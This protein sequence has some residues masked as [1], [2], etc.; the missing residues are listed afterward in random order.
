MWSLRRRLNLMVPARCWAVRRRTLLAF[1]A[2]VA[3]AA[4]ALSSG[5]SRLTREEEMEA[6]LAQMQAHLEFLTTL[7]RSRQIEVMNMQTKMVNLGNPEQ[8]EKLL[9]PSTTVSPEVAQ[10]LKNLTGTKTASGVDRKN[11]QPQTLPFIY[12]LMPH[13]LDDVYSL[14]PAFHMRG[15]R[16][17]AQIVI[18]IPTVKRDKESYLMVTLTHLISGM[19]EADQKESVIIVMVGEPDLEF[20]INTAKQIETLFPKEVESGLIEVISPPPSY[21]PNFDSFEPTLGDSSKRMRW[22]TKQN[23][24]T[25]FLMAYAQSRGTFYLMLEDDVIAKQHYMRDIKY[26]TAQITIQTPQWFFIE[27]CAFGGIGKLFRSADL[28]H[29]ITYVQL[30]YSNMPIDWLLE[31]YLADKVCSIYKSS[32]ECAKSKLDIRPKYKSS[33]FQHIGLYSSLK[34]KI[35]KVQDSRYGKLPGFF[36]HQNPD[37]ET[38]HNDIEEKADHTIRRAYNGETFFWGIKPKKGDV[39]EFV[40]RKPTVLERYTFRSGNVDHASDKFYD[41]YIEIQPV[42]GNY[43]VIDSF[44]EFGLADGS[45]KGDW[46]PL[47]SI[48]L[49]VN[50]DSTFWV[51]LSEIELKPYNPEER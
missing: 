44:D 13:L 2:L 47:N 38:I 8:S 30:F 35:Q 28:S 50:R 22:R 12:Q 32:K 41:T 25:I 36:P 18:G 33:L 46:G 3:L 17:L 21:Y 43:T 7:Y 10:L 31:S 29:F 11:L 1:L 4:L 5:G 27:Y 14:R 15:T 26:F 16:Q 37:L 20:V 19:T 39:I 23:L 9:G 45:L 24:D 42:G 49:R 34:G 40:F 6:R 51:I 48:R